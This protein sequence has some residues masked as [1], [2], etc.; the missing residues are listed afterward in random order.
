MSRPGR[1]APPHRAQ[2]YA[3]PQEERLTGMPANIGHESDPYGSALSELSRTNHSALYRSAT[4]QD[5][6]EDQ[7]IA[8]GHKHDDQDHAILWH[9]IGSWIFTED[10]DSGGREGKLVT[11]TA[12]TDLALIP[13]RFSAGDAWNQRFFLRVRVSNPAPTYVTYTNLR[14]F[15]QFLDL[16]GAPKTRQTVPPFDVTIQSAAAKVYSDQ[17]LTFGPYRFAEPAGN[18]ENWYLQLQAAIATAGDKAMLW[19]L[20]AGYL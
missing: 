14:I 8:E 6:D 9:Q 20:Q 19:E 5:L 2:L 18:A 12:L 16:G 11:A 1:I 7:T 3:P 13:W 4:G 10:S 17:W 15:G